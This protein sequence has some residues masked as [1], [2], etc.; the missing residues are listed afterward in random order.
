MTQAGLPVSSVVLL[1]RMCTLKSDKGM[2]K[3]KQ[4]LEIRI[5]YRVCI[6]Y[7]ELRRVTGL[8]GL[9]CR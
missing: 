7:V 8:L 6:P 5:P 3:I 4:I 2:H 9:L 1:V